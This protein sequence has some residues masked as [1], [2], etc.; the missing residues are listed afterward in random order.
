MKRI[1]LA[2]VFL[3][4]VQQLHAQIAE[5]NKFI[6]GTINL[7]VLGNSE[8]T[9]TAFALTPTFGYFI[10][11]QTA[12]GGTLGVLIQPT[13]GSD[14][15]LTIFLSPFIRRYFPIADDQFY[16]FLDGTV[17]L[18]YGSSAA[19]FGEFQSSEDAFSVSLVASP[20]FAYFPA[21]RWSLDFTFTGFGLSFFDIGG[22]GGTTTL[23]T[24]GAT[25]FSPSLG[26][27]YYF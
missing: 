17:A 26:F 14:N 16:F 2:F 12:V 21:E 5:G 13:G 1:F 6:N 19:G 3:L 4:S 22:E 10:N 18:S 20:G 25:S 8:D 27:S 9:Q 24:I 15:D 11:D 7:T 23:F